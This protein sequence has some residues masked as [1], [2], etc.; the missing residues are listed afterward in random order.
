MIIETLMFAIPGKKRNSLMQL[1]N[2]R[3]A[4]CNG[5]VVRSEIIVYLL[6]GDFCLEITHTRKQQTKENGVTKAL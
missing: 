5:D 1:A 3:G 6:F 4:H 2:T